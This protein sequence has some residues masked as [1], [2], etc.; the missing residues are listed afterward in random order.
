MT[1]R[2]T[3]RSCDV[4]LRPPP[5]LAEGGPRALRAPPSGP[6]SSPWPRPGAGKTTFALT[7]A[8]QRPRRAPRAAG[9]R[10]GPDPAP[11]AP[12]GPGRRPLRP[13]PRAAVVGPRRPPARRH[14]RHR[15]HLPAGRHAGPGAAGHRPRCLRDLRRAPPR[16]RRAGLGRR[17]PGG[18]RAGA[19]RRLAISGTP[20][21]SR[22]RRHP[23][24]RLRRLRRGP[25]RLRVRLR[26]R[27]RATAASS[28][29]STSPA[30]TATWSGSAPT[31]PQYAHTFDDALDHARS[32]QRLRTALSLSGRVAARRARPGP[33]AAPG[34]PGRAA[35]RRRPGHRHGP[36]AR[37]RH[38]RAAAPPPRRA[39]HP[40]R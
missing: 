29:P 20:F 3:R 2:Y 23:V 27:P 11:Q 34:H 36:G 25:L 30:S 22:H 24:R 1:G 12:V 21:R 6:T 39:R 14:A 15:R 28:G 4:A 37:P 33:R 10:G 40:G 35:P 26:R 13:A 17:H 8:V 5:A 31:A 32:G 19:A 7:A 18:L 38:R 16:R 9:R